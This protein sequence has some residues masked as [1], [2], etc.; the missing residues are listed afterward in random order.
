MNAQFDALQAGEQVMDESDDYFCVCLHALYSGSLRGDA[1][2]FSRTT[3]TLF[4]SGGDFPGV[5][6]A[7]SSQD[8]I[9]ESPGYGFWRSWAPWM[10]NKFLGLW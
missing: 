2:S 6:W 1:F 10:V 9:G 4:S 7:R 8:F 5:P 3:A